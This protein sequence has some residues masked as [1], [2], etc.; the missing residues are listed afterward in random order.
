[1]TSDQELDLPTSHWTEEPKTLGGICVAVRP[2]P[3]ELGLAVII[4]EA[5]KTLARQA[6]HQLLVVPVRPTR[7]HEFPT[8]GMAD[9]IKWTLSGTLPVVNDPEETP[10]SQVYDP[11]LR[12]HL[13]LG[14][15]IVKVAISSVN[16]HGTTVQWEEWTGIDLNTFVKADSSKVA[17]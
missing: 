6:G 14:G 12:K 10:A 16:V 4:L 1:M 9:Y 5:M 13:C 7:K 2:D 3:R 17:V 8:M 15:Q 11:W